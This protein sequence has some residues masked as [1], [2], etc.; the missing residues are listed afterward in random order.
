MIWMIPLALQSSDAL[1]WGLYTHVYFAQYLVWSVTL[2]DP[3]FRRALKRF[4]ESVLAGACLPDLALFGFSS[5]TAA[6][7]DSHTWTRA[8]RII[9]RCE[10]DRDRALALGYS[11]H[12]L[13]DTVAH[14]HFVPDHRRL[15][16]DLPA[17]THVLSEWAMDSF[18][19]LRVRLRPSQLVHRH[20]PYLAGYVA[21][22]FGCPVREAMRALTQLKLA[23]GALRGIRIPDGIYR[24]SR[25]FD[26]RVR[27]RFARYA[28]A[29]AALLHRIDG[30]LAGQRP[31]LDPEPL[32]GRSDAKPRDK[33]AD[34]SPDPSQLRWIAPRRPR[35]DH[36]QSE[37]CATSAPMAAPARTSLG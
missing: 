28:G 36:S 3:A 27:A 14:N 12:L 2:A 30:V 29:T 16:A 4:P 22:Q 15:W 17:V 23:E 13:A 8:S 11:S 25:C 32:P 10:C 6:F 37:I 33:R 26:S 34:L 20:Q 9:S 18:L 24:V 31:E 7:R 21:A 19:R 1:A 35:A 5:G